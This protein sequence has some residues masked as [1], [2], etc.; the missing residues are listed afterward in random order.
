LDS[1]LLHNLIAGGGSSSQFV[2]GLVVAVLYAVI[3]SLGAIGSILVFRRIFPGRW[4]Q[5]FWASFLVV[6]AA[7][8]LSF[9]AYFGASPH[10]W[11]TELI[12]VGV[13]LVCAWVVFAICYCNGYILHGLWDLS[14]CLSGSSLAGVSITDIPLGYGIFC[15]AFDFVV[16]AYL[17]ISD[18]AWHKP[19]KFDPYFW[20][21]IARAD[22][23]IE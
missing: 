13:F 11:Q 7:F 20:R 16:A 5:I 15:S 18:T 3:G 2:G 10:A 22:E 14:H 6:I 9:A 21:H 17:M 8:Y 19:G 1:A 12:G 23:V 4:E